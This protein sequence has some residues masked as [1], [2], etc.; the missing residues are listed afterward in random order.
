MDIT[1]HKCAHTHSKH[2]FKR[3]CCLLNYSC[4]ST[5]E[6]HNPDGEGEGWLFCFHIPRHFL[7]NPAL[8][9]KQMKFDSQSLH[10]NP[11]FITCPHT[12]DHPVYGVSVPLEKFAA[13][14]LHIWLANRFSYLWRLSFLWMAS[15]IVQGK[16][17][18]VAET[19]QFLTVFMVLDLQASLF[20]F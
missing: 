2:N 7:S 8:L 11:S 15:C 9:W 19:P 20:P 5:S 16:R 17:H 13:C 18:C 10:L 12:S 1:A 14:L 4:F 6:S 3:F